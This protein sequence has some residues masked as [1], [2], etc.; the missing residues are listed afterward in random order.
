MSKSSWSLLKI[1]IKKSR[2]H[3]LDISC[4]YINNIIYV[5]VSPVLPAALSSYP[6]PAYGSKGNS[7]WCFSKG[8]RLC[9]RKSTT[10]ILSEN[11]PFIENFDGICGSY[12]THPT[13]KRIYSLASYW[14]Y[15][16]FQ[17]DPHII[18]EL[19][20]FSLHPIGALHMAQKP[21]VCGVLA[22][23][24]GCV[25]EC[26]PQLFWVKMAHSLKIWMEFVAVLTLIKQHKEYIPWLLVIPNFSDRPTY[27]LWFFAIFTPPY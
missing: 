5:C 25:E 20:H 3:L 14:S 27:N 21:I 22:K 12:N 9:G 10:A 26:L 7:L 23:E 2:I 8:R 15:L 11:G 18:F 6:G 17:I 4:L 13:T 1:F 24:G 19:L 16:T